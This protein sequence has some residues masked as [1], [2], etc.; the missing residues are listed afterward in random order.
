MRNFLGNEPRISDAIE[1]G[2]SCRDVNHPPYGNTD[3]WNQDWYWDY[4]TVE[5]KSDNWCYNSP[6]EE[7]AIDHMKFLT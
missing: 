4:H 3:F 1:K 6:Y 7:K 2:N 5:K